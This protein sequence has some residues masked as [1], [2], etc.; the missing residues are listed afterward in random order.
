MKNTLAFVA[1]VGAMAFGMSLSAQ[2]KMDCNKEFSDFW[3][4]INLQGGQKLDGAKLADVQ[5][6]GLRGYDA[7]Q[8]GDDSAPGTIWKQLLDE[9]KAR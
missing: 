2:A 8:S 9:V 5:R 7:C 3:N 4:K 1:A 6:R